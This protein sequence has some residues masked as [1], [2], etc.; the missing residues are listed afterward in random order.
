MRVMP[1]AKPPVKHDFDAGCFTVFAPP[2]STAILPS[3]RV[4][5]DLGLA[6]RLPPGMGGILALKSSIAAKYRLRL[7]EQRL[8]ESLCS[9]P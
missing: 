8:G 7:I 5:L 6:V 4:R 2:V 3:T 1:D 9:P